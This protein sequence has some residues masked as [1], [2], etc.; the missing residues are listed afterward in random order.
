VL[1]FVLRSTYVR[2]VK[3]ISVFCPKLLRHVLLPNSYF[4]LIDQY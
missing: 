1:K 2:P 3:K 4:I